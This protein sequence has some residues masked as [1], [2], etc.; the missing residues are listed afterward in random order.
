MNRKNENCEN[1][2]K[3]QHLNNLW[4]IFLVSTILLHI[5]W[6]FKK[7]LLNKINEVLKTS[8]SAMWTVN[9]LTNF[10]TSFGIMRS[11]SK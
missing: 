6:G 10:W 5:I 9:K 11:I 8:T 2:I 4:E 1:I 7:F 3:D